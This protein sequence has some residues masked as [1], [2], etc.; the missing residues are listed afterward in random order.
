MRLSGI[1]TEIKD[2]SGVCYCLTWI[3]FAHLHSAFSVS[4]EMLS[5]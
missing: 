4:T 2:P 3:K 1:Y 5:I